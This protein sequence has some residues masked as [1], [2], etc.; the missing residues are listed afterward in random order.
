MHIYRQFFYFKNDFYPDGVIYLN[1]LVYNSNAT[2]SF[3]IYIDGILLESYNYP[4]NF[5]QNFTVNLHDNIIVSSGMF[6]MSQYKGISAGKF[7]SLDIL[8]YGNG[9]IGIEGSNLMGQN[10]KVGLKID[11]LQLD[12]WSKK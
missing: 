8:N 4:Y 9:K 7:I 3:A 5:E 6:G 10:L 1:N 11:I 12:T 2:N